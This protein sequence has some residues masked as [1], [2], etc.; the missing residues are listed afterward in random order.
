MSRLNIGD[1]VQDDEMGIGIIKSIY[2]DDNLDDGI[3]YYIWWMTTDQLT[4]EHYCDLSPVIDNE[5]LLQ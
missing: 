2:F 3:I 5:G 4:F 1:I